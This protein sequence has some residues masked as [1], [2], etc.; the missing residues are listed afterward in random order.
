[1]IE[2]NYDKAKQMK[3]IASLDVAEL[4]DRISHI[5]PEQWDT[6]EDFKV[7]Y[8]KHDKG[9][10][11]STEHIIFKFVN[12]QEVPFTYFEGSRWKAWE[13]LLMPIMEQT[14]AIYD[15]DNG[16]YPKVMLAKMPPETFIMPHTDGDER[17]YAPHKIHVPV[18]TNPKAFFFEENRR[19]HLVAGKAYEVNNGGTHSVVNGGETDRIHLIFEYLDLD[20]QPAEL[21]ERMLNPVV[22]K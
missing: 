11:R 2:I 16:Y 22:L 7:N 10:L 5:A 21:K 19:H 1:M 3:T 20:L 6:A 15:Y 18:E 12:K 9:A 17:G 4:K 8:N 14:T 13:D